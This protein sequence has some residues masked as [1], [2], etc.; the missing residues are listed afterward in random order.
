MFGR[1]LSN[2]HQRIE[3]DEEEEIGKHCMYSIFACGELRKCLFAES[4]SC[5]GLERNQA[6]G[7]DRE[8][9][10]GD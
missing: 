8:R 1:Q 10:N 9:A 2:R 4:Y 7:E 3:Q 6:E 5:S